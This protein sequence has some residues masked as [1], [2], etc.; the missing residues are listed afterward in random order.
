MQN[1]VDNFITIC[2]NDKEKL[3]WAWLDELVK[4]KNLSV[5]DVKAILDD[6]YADSCDLHK[7]YRLAGLECITASTFNKV[8]HFGYGKSMRVINL[9]LRH[10]AIKKVSFGYAITDLEAFKKVGKSL[11]K[12][13]ENNV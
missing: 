13:E 9:L 4:T 11:F 1:E 5:E 3:T 8:F 10:N 7:F 12:R 2:K 6:I